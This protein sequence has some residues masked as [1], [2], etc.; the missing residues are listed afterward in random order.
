MGGETV[1]F[2]LS[3]IFETP[4]YGFDDSSVRTAV[5]CRQF[6]GEV[7]QTVMLDLGGA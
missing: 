5:C 4:R 7:D 2:V 1:Q 6:V 3:V